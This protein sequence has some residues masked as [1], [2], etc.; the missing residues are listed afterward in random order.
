MDLH[1]KTVVITGSSKGLGRA[2]AEAFLKKGA[3]VVINSR[4]QDELE[5]IAEELECSYFAAD[6][7]KEVDIRKMGEHVLKEFGRIDVWVNNAGLWMPHSQIEDMDLDMVRRLMEVNLF[8]TIHGSRVAMRTMKKQGTGIIV[9]I[10]SSSALVGRANSSGYAATKW[11]ARGFTQS[12]RAALKTEGIQVVAVHPGGIKTEI[13][14]EASIP[15]YENFMEPDYVASEIVE[16]LG[17][18]IP[19]LELK[20]IKS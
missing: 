5:K 18:K 1:G 3:N 16:N 11:A 9:N 6:V 15:G 19:E 4:S 12:L 13:F 8:G 10:I 14:G 17:K 7:A 20:I 2:L